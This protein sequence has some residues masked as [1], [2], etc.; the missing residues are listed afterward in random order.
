MIFIANW[1]QNKNISEVKNWI[2][3]FGHKFKATSNIEVVIAPSSPYLHM[4]SRLS[5]ELGVSIAAQDVSMFE[6]GPQTGLVGASQIKDFCKY[7]ILGHSE[8]RARGESN[9]DVLAKIDLSLKAGL[10]PIVCFKNLAEFSSAKSHAASS[11]F[12]YAYEPLESIGTG[13]PASM[14][15][16][17]NIQKQTG[18]SSFIYG[19]SV[20]SK[21]IEEYTN[22][23]ILIGFLI[24]TSALDPIEFSSIISKCSN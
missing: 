5:D 20:S 9:S 4:L 7:V 1:K 2:D 21:N 14:E 16:I 8:S 15:S 22:S 3:S 23:P 12:L 10:I 24:G 6:N 13:N 19:G 17:I 11:M 18:L